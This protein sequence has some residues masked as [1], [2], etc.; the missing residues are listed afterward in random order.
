MKVLTMN[1]ISEEI[2]DLL[3][4]LLAATEGYKG[5]FDSEDRATWSRVSSREADIRVALQEVHKVEEAA[6]TEVEELL[7]EA[8]V[9]R[10]QAVRGK[11]QAVALEKE[12]AE[13]RIRAD[14]LV[15]SV[16]T[17]RERM[18]RRDVQ[19]R[20]A[21]TEDDAAKMETL[22]QKLKGGG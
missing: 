4:Q 10:D 7:T 13:H 17:L 14:S 1:I 11:H 15:Q 20:Q 18:Q 3:E 8:V 2:L 22:A 9:M 5:D 6:S 16:I 12:A 19:T 21:V